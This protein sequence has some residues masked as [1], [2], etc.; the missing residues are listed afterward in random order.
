MEI[1]GIYVKHLVQNLHISGKKLVSLDKE[2]VFGQNLSRGN[3]QIS[4]I[5]EVQMWRQNLINRMVHN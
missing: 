1:L 2:F 3:W 4:G 5:N